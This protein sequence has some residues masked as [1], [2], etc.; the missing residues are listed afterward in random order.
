MKIAAIIA[1]I[2][3]SAIAADAAA[4][5]NPALG[6]VG[7]KVETFSASKDNSNVCDSNKPFR[8]NWRVYAMPGEVRP[9]P[10]VCQAGEDQLAGQSTRLTHFDSATKAPTTVAGPNEVLVVYRHGSKTGPVTW[11][12]QMA[13][14]GTVAA[15]AAELLP[16]RCTSK[17]LR[18][19]SKSGEKFTMKGNEEVSNNGYRTIVCGK[20]LPK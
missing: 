20:N 13:A 12:E 7:Y 4:T 1:A 18:M 5:A 14:L 9:A 10:I 11:V 17:S 19:K 15:P 6:F 2:A 3:A 16:V 8:T